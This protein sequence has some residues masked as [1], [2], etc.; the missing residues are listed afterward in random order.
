MRHYQ[1]VVVVIR[2]LVS[3]FLMGV[4]SDDQDSSYQKETGDLALELLFQVGN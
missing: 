1:S 4:A 3:G 2:T